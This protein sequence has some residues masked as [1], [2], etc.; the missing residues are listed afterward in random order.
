MIIFDN[1]KKE[2]TSSLSRVSHVIIKLGTGVLTRHIDKNDEEF[3]LKLADQIKIIQSEGKKVLIVSSGAVGFGKKIWSS[4]I[5]QRDPDLFS[6]QEKQALASLGQSLLMDTYRSEFDKRQLIAAQILV[7][8]SD[9]QKRSHFMHLKNTLDKLLEWGAVPVINEN[10]AVTVEGLRFGD[11]D[12]LSALIAGMY[13][14][15]CLIILTTVDGFYMNGKK[16]DLLTKVTTEEMKAAGN[17]SKGGVGGMRTKLVAARKILLSGQIMNIASG[18][19]PSIISGVLQGNSV[20]TWFIPENM[21]V[22]NAKK[23]W[24]LHHKYSDGKIFIDKGAE[25]ALYNSGASLLIVGILSADGN[26]TKGDSVDIINLDHKIIG[27]GVVSINRSDLDKLMATN[28]ITRGKEI[29]HRDSL[30]IFN[31]EEQ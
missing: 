8:I 17:P 1:I 30:V 26:F 27:R 2:L 31:R 4:K 20:G 9:F 11:N 22:F 10:D 16:V 18:K 13:P 5:T 3:F 6:L 19:D 12:T 24:L 21:N 15:S 29:I 23:R 25:N 14:S 28:S 7:S